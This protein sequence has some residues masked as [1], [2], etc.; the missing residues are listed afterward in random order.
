MAHQLLK[1][2]S[3]L[4]NLSLSEAA[5]LSFVISKSDYTTHESFI[6]NQ[7]IA[8]HFSITEKTVRRNLLSL[9]SKKIITKESRRNKW[10][11][12]STNIIKLNL[13]TDLSTDDQNLDEKVPQ[14]SHL[15]RNKITHWASN[16]QRCGPQMSN[17]DD[18]FLFNISKYLSITV[19]DEK[20][21]RDCVSFFSKKIE[22][23]EID[24]EQAETFP[25]PVKAI[26]ILTYLNSKR[27]GYRSYMPIRANLSLIERLLEESNT[28]MT[29]KKI[30]DLKASTWLSRDDMKK[31]FRPKTLFN[32]TNVAN[33]VGEL[34]I[35]AK[36][37]QSIKNL[38][39]IGGIKMADQ[40]CMIGLLRDEKCNKTSD[41][42][43]AFKVGDESKV[44]YLCMN[45]YELYKPITKLEDLLMMKGDADGDVK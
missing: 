27:S 5:I 44:F 34:E 45:H 32:P 26:L 9:I 36:K 23:E 43:I 22:D 3:G 39:S 21:S 7:T 35:I 25:L 10:G 24:W 2:Y 16:V 37:A 15:D 11:K 8:D 1:W 38:T 31:Y 20:T 12:F 42:H 19:F 6:R 4:N 30:I 28:M 33:Y 17:G 14:T 40:P 18:L 29:I 41:A 13:S